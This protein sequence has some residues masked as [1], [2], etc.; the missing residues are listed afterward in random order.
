MKRLP[1]A[2]V[3]LL[4]GVT[5]LASALRW[6][7]RRA[8]VAAPAAFGG[9]GAS[10]PHALIHGLGAGAPP[11]GVAGSSGPAMLH[12]DGRHTHRASGR[13]PVSTPAVAWS[14]DV[15]GPVE[16]QVTLSPDEQTLYVAS[17]GGSL[18][19]LA[20]ADGA[21]RWSVAL[22]DR[23]YAT[24]CVGRDGT[25][26]AGSDAKKLVALAPD[27]KTK[28]SF[29]TDGD[30]DTGPVLSTDGS[31]VFAAGRTV[32]ALSP[33]GLVR[34]RFAA[35]RK[36]FTSPAVAA[37]GRVFFGSQDHHAYALS[38]QGV[39]A[40]STDL[41]ADVDGAPVLA[42]DGAV[43]VG[44]DLDE[45][46]RLD[47][48]TGSVAWRVKLGGYVRGAL[49]VARNG[50]VLAGVYGPTP[51]QVRVRGADGAVV[52]E[53]AVQ[54]T[55]AREFG[56]HGG[57]LEDD[58][59]TL[60]FGAQDDVVYAVAAGGELLWRFVTGGDVDAPLTLLADGTVVVGSDDG[61][62]YLLRGM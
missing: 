33:S 43:F 51:R 53:F 26:Y 60:L 29:D 59:G 17:L 58:G 40:W 38:A 4:V 57:A 41:G 48:D 12:G 9:P 55:G 7:A 56:V 34:W 20:R 49:S 19:A 35:K 11:A 46:V 50:D 22:G 24:P 16:A 39:L 44:T 15:G 6:R 47:A 10:S 62:V 5:L 8:H 13:A 42:D 21:E 14:H 2:V 54:G 3:V 30:A 52:G 31:V 18:T 23:A 28:W 45:L 36:V 37:D 25:I 32:Y 61:K 1:L 27:G